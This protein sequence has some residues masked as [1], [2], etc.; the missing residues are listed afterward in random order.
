MRNEISR[1]APIGDLL[2]LVIVLPWGKLLA[3]FQEEK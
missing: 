1:I 3:G 2:F